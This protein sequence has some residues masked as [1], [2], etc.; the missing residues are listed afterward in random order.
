MTRDSHTK[1]LS[2]CSGRDGQVKALRWEGAGVLERQSGRIRP[3]KHCKE[4]VW[5]WIL[6]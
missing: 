4:G 5:I 2:E 3:G 1:I 6:F